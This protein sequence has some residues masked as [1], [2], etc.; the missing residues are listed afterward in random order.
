MAKQSK[1]WFREGKGAWYA[2]V[3]GRQTSLGV[4]GLDNDGEAVKA[5]H[6]LMADGPKPPAATVKAATVKQV[7]DGFLAGAETL[8][9][10]EAEAYARKSEWS[11]TYRSNFLASLVSAYRWAERGQVIDR[12]VLRH[13]RKPPKASRGAKA[14]ISADDHARLVAYASPLFRPF[15]RLLFLTGARPGEI[16]GLKA[17][18]VDLAQGVAVLTHH[19]TAHLGKSRTVYLCP[20]AVAV[21]RERIAVH[22]QGLLF[23]GELKG[24]RLSAQAIGRRLFRLCE[25]AGVKSHIAYGSISVA[26]AQP[27]CPR[28]WDPTARPR[29]RF[30]A[31]YTSARPS[32]LRYAARNCN[33]ASPFRRP[34]LLASL[35]ATVRL[36]DHALHRRTTD[37]QPQ[38]PIFGIVHLVP[39]VRHVAHRVRRHPA[40]VVLL[41]LRRRRPQTLRRLPQR[42]Q[43][44]PHLPRPGPTQPTLVQRPGRL[45]QRRGGRLRRRVQIGNQM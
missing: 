12:N 5:W 39:V 8:T 1:P 26:R 10:A 27:F 31:A 22:P 21:L 3:Q 6:R 11:M 37:R 14:I 25:K 32:S 17:E 42:R 35:D 16:A 43:Q 2:T 33:G 44:R 45:P 29:G 41:R 40:R 30:R 28:R 9:V 7:I 15:L 34:E 4:K 19:K 23:P 24:E 18:E 13:L 38:P 20:E 36:L